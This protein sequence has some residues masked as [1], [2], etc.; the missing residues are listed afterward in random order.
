[1]ENACREERRLSAGQH[2]L[3]FRQGVFATGSCA[4]QAFGRAGKNK[5]YRI[6][7]WADR[8]LSSS[9]WL[10]EVLIKW[11]PLHP[12]PKNTAA[13]VVP[14]LVPIKRFAGNRAVS[15]RNRRDNMRKREMT[16]QNWFQLWLTGKGP[17]LSRIFPRTRFIWKA[18]GRNIMA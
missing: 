3:P 10:R 12:A 6:L 18:G 16:V 17:E 15:S 13:R 8:K 2:S 1:M 9:G 5:K 14:W 7:S 4:D 11:P